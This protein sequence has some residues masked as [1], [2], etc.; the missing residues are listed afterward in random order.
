MM[1]PPDRFAGIVLLRPPGGGGAEDLLAA[2]DTLIQVARSLDQAAGLHGRLWI[3][4]PGK[5][6][7]Y[8]PLD[9]ESD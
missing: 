1:Y 4:Q 7:E 9:T 8:C 5:V 3:I 2:I 6:R